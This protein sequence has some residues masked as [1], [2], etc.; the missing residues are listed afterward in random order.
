METNDGW[1]ILKRG[2]GGDGQPT[3]IAVCCGKNATTMA[4][5]S[6]LPK[7]RALLTKCSAT[8]APPHWRTNAQHWSSLTTSHSPSEAMTTNSASERR[9]EVTC[10]KQAKP[11]ASRQKLPRPR[12]MGS[13]P[14]TH[15]HS[16]V[17]PAAWMRLTS[18]GH[19][20]VWSTLSLCT[21]PP[22]RATTARESPALQHQIESPVE[23]TTMAVLPPRNSSLRADS[24][25]SQRALLSASPGEFGQ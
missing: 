5:S 2:A 16:T 17:P 19:E 4:M 3:S 9:T 10:G 21:P 1:C 22:R 12:V 25:A 13:C 8:P 7:L 20:V 23:A 14:P 18:S 11:S 15:P 24:L 6:E